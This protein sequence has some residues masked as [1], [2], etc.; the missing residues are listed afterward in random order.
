MRTLG[1]VITISETQTAHQNKRYYIIGEAHR[2]LCGA[3]LL[4]TTWYLETAPESPFPWKLDDVD[5]SEL[6]TATYLAF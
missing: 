3:T 5:R 6:G 1:D 2:L 4:E